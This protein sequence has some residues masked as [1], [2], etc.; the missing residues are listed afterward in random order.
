M[1]VVV[2]GLGAAAARASCRAHTS[3]PFFLNT[4]ED[5]DLLY[6]LLKD[7]VKSGK[8][9]SVWVP[10]RRHTHHKKIDRPLAP[11]SPARH[12]AHRPAH[13]YDWL[14]AHYDRA[15]DTLALL[16]FPKRVMRRKGI[17]CV[18]RQGQQ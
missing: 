2:G 6:W 12:P 14:S 8:V 5:A 7:C 18:R 13:E 10:A 16:P 4:Q 11:P 15:S 3:T 9:D 1:V 17:I